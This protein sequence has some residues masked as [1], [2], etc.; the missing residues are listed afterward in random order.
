MLSVEGCAA[1]IAANMV[2]PGQRSDII[3]CSRLVTLPDWQGMGLA[4]RL[5]DRLGACYRAVGRELRTYPA[6][7]SLIRAFDKSPKWQMQKRPG[8]ISRRNVW[9]GEHSTGRLGG[10]HCAV[11]SYAGQPEADVETARGLVG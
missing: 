3:A 2:L 8:A 10:R 11:F 1:S 5:I 4:M 7:P 9:K 6:H